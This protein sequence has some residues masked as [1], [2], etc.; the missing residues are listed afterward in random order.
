[1]RLDLFLPFLRRRKKSFQPR[2]RLLHRFLPL[3]LFSDW[4]SATPGPV[5]RGLARLGPTWVSAPV[6][7]GVQTLCF[8][9]F[10]VLLFYT[11][12]PY[13][14][15]AGQHTQAFA[16]KELVH[17]ELF[18]ALDPLVSLS[19]AV[20][21]RS[22]VW[23]LCFAAAI[24]AL[25][26]IFP[27]GFCGYLCPLGTLIDLSDW[28]LGKRVTRFRIQKDGWWVN[29]KYYVLLGT[30]VSAIGGGLISGFLSAI[31]VLT[32]AFVYILGPLQMGLMRG[33][34]QVPPLHAGHYVS[35]AM[36][37]AVLGLGFLRPR[38]WCRYVCPTG[39]L[40]SISSLFVRAIERKVED[41]CIS[42]NKCVEICPFD[43][44]KADFTT[45]IPDCTM[46]MTCGG[47]CPTHSIKFVPRW[48]Q[49][50]LK[51]QEEVHETAVSRRWFMAASVGG[52]AV[53]F[54]LGNSIA[55]PT[56]PPPIRPPGSVPEREFLQLCIRCGECF[57]ACPN[58]VLQ[59][60]GFEG[61]LNGL[62]APV[63]RPDWA[64]CEPSCTACGQV[65]PT[66]AI[67]ALPIEEKR[68]AR[69]GLAQVDRNACLPW[70]GAEACQLCV[71]ECN[72]AGYK[73][74]EFEMHGTETDE[75][76]LPIEGTGKLA[77]VIKPE[78]CVGCGLCQTRCNKIN[79]NQ[80]GLLT[81]SAVVVRAGDGKEDR[82]MAGSY[83][84]LREREASIRQQEQQQRRKKL[85]ATLGGD[86]FY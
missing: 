41:S 79:V 7:R 9:L 59:P 44:I 83:R 35:I 23:S 19:T 58:N 70:A 63:V 64:G 33:W 39:A 26:W 31:P 43:A 57:K 20:A 56:A 17:S 11:C 82:M 51:E 12:W 53:A 86:D 69:I 62:W 29:L 45:R 32:R 65:C 66:G 4:D 27:R 55:A 52:A 49:D 10:C 18:L 16:A 54:G 15:P 81:S 48:E 1:M 60:A 30:L 67:R 84:R 24:L 8:S 3:L 34:Y 85:Q 28:V 38:F 2:T 21:S 75:N 47:V 25:G 77:P 22:W 14:I 76:G 13:G 5:R 46:C 61:G 68:V 40:F 73:A 71:D 37:L 42:C 50:N 78:L 80:K 36:F 6:R 72:A 74:I